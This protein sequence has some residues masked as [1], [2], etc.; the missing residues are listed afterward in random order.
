MRTRRRFTAD[1]KAK[2]ALEALRCGKTIQEIAAK[3]VVHPEPGKRVEA[4]GDGRSG[5]G[6]LERR[7]ACE[8]GSRGGDRSA[9]R[10]DRP[11]DSGTGGLI[12]A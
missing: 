5:R 8:P 1:F 6:V 3:H 11:V 4:S 12:A 10:Q 7:R 9:A 2:V